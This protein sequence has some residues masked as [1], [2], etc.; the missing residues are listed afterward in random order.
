MLKSW[1]FLTVTDPGSEPAAD[2]SSVV[3][4]DIFFCADTERVKSTD[5]NSILSFFIENILSFE[6]TVQ[7]EKI[8]Y[9][10]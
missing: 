3:Y 10:L 9:Y 8:R 2:N 5:N 7:H 4:D 1:H 6:N